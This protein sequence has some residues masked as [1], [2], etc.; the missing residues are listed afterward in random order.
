MGWILKGNIYM[1]DTGV[2][3]SCLQKYKIGTWKFQLLKKQRLHFLGQKRQIMF[4][5]QEC[6]NIY[7]NVLLNN[8]FMNFANIVM[9][10]CS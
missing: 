5:T 3:F 9:I 1:L 4:S 8:P 7:L 10:K 6:V 2:L